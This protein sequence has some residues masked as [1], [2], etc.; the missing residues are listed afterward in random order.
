MPDISRWYKKEN[1]DI[2][3]VMVY[4]YLYTYLINI[5]ILKM[6]AH[7]LK[8]HE[9]LHMSLIGIK[10]CARN[11]QKINSEPFQKSK[12]FARIVLIYK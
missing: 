11:S 6:K 9:L 3:N 12:V 10:G 8:S 1:M 4:A 2:Q 7:K 5:P